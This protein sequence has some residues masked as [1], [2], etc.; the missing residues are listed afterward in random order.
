MTTATSKTTNGNASVDTSNATSATPAQTQPVAPVETPKVETPEAESTPT[1]EPPK[2]VE[3]PVFSS[4]LIIKLADEIK[5]AQ[6]ETSAVTLGSSKLG[7][8]DQSNRKGKRGNVDI[9]MVRKYEPNG[10]TDTYKL[11]DPDPSD[12]SKVI[13][14]GNENIG[15]LNAIGQANKARIELLNA[16]YEN[17]K[18]SYDNPVITA[19][20]HNG[21]LLRAGNLI[22]KSYSG[23][24]I[25][26][27]VV[28]LHL[29]KRIA[30][31]SIEDR[32]LLYNEIKTLT[33][34]EE[35]LAN[36]DR[37]TIETLAVSIY[38]ALN[39]MHGFKAVEKS[40]AK[41]ETPKTVSLSDVLSMDL[42]SQVTAKASPKS[43]GKKAE[44]NN[45]P[46]GN[47][48]NPMKYTKPSASD[49]TAHSTV[50]ST[51]PTVL[52]STSEKI[53]DPKQLEAIAMAKAEADKKAEESK[54]VDPVVSP[55]SEKKAEEPK[56]AD[57]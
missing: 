46:T 33:V 55:E 57:K 45:A 20:V 37:A 29:V 40:A 2:A 18:E 4:K 17:P 39:K 36:I 56:T 26:D 35:S 31:W 1:V 12:E 6:R 13:E 5:Q 7:S 19:M 38:D 53:D 25:A 16:E 21:V 52:A 28:G 24:G 42:S 34:G 50:V 49:N 23:G 3:S 22:L 54:N 32:D 10:D 51:T 30:K 48:I 43:T 15:K 47:A 27:K 8:Q 14:K 9:L 41:G 11:G 44:S